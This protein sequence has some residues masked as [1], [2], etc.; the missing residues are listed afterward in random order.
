M[1]DCPMARIS[2]SSATESSCIRSSLMMR[3]RVG[4]ERS[5]KEWMIDAIADFSH[6]VQ[7]VGRKLVAG[8]SL[9]PSSHGG[10]RTIR[11]G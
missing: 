3:R 8:T 2:W 5:L 7:Q 9:A 10:G 4:S 1:R 11:Q 6:P